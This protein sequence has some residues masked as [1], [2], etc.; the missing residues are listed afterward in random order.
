M[1]RLISIFSAALLALSAHA[2][3]RAFDFGETPV[4]Q[5]PTNFHALVAGR[6]RPAD[7]KILLDDVP[8]VLAPLTSKAESV[9]KRPVLAQVTREPFSVRFPLFIFDGDTY[10]DFKFTARFKLAGGA[11]AEAAGLVFRFENESNFFIVLANGTE[12]TFQCTRVIDG[13]M[14]PP[15]PLNPPQIQIGKGQWHNISIQCE[16]TRITGSLDGGDQIKL[17]DNSAA[18]I[19]G[20]IGFCTR[21]DAVTYFADARVTFTSSEIFAQKLVQSALAEYSRLVNLKIYAARPGEK[22]PAVVASKNEKE[23]GQPGAKAERDVIKSGHSYYGK[24]KETVTVILPL[25]DRNGD[26]MAAVALEM[27]TFTGQ[28]EDNALTRAQPIIRK[29]QAQVQS[30]DDLLE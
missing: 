30:L 7:W 12:G 18:K 29:L 19:I 2:A 8:P 24:G 11:L 4:D 3:E 16:G 9:T 21:A 25:R 5:T 1:M 6:G 17:V 13:K 14:Q 26:P 27:K 10:R 15:L 22:E 23:L 20:K 28:T